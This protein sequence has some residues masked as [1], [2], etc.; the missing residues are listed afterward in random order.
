VFE[1]NLGPKPIHSKD[2]SEDALINALN[3]VK[4][5][6]RNLVIPLKYYQINFKWK[7]V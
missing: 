2:L 7:K 4:K 3:S 6:M 5:I 1:L